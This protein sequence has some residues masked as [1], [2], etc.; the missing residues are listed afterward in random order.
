VTEARTPTLAEVVAAVHRRYD[1]AWAEHWDAVGLVCG[2]PEAPV[3]RI[4]LAVDP[5]AA[6][7][8][9][10][11]DLG[12][13]LLLTHHPLLLRPVSSVAAT[14]PPG[15][16][17]HRLIRGGVGLLAAHTNADSAPGGVSDALAAVAGLGDVD[18]LV[19]AP[20][21]GTDKYVVF[22]PAEHLDAVLDAVH[23]AGAGVIGDYDRCASVIGATSGRFRPL[24]G[25]EPF[26]GEVGTAQ[27]VAEAR[28]EFVAPRSRRDAVVAA[29]RAAHPYDEPA[30]DVLEL[31]PAPSGVG[32]GRVG[33]LDA[34]V[35]LGTLADRVAAGVPATA[36]G[37]RVA[38]DLDR[39]VR[40]I[41]VCGG[42]GSDL[43]GAA[44]AAGADVLVTADLKHHQV[45]DARELG[46]LAL[47]DLAHWASEWPWLPMAADRLV[48]DLAADGATV[49]VHVSELMT[50]PW[51]ARR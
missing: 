31:V 8:Q 36:Q 39:E 30:Y 45:L 15:R 46:D 21:P 18:P 47:V 29:L 24:P 41:A 6:T 38:G 34:A 4:L 17:L 7:A 50:D 25:A 42:A 35:T 26:L 49:E 28:A 48:A 1:P 44:R 23:E 10:A 3:R 16:L 19:P 11:L 20:G 27:E 37:V 51:T 12:A 9:E 40:R 33:D 43:I 13:D 14:T 32:L 22:V 5:V 2:D